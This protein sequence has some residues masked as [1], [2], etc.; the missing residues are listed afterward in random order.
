MAIFRV[1]M[2]DGSAEAVVRAQCLTCAKQKVVERAQPKDIRKWRE[3]SVE[4]IRNPERHGY[5]AEGK[6]G[7][8]KWVCDGR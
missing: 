2:R 3:A 8:I 1:S 6:S 7:I 4:L 5:L